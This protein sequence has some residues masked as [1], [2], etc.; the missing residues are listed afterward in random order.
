MP[1]SKNICLRFRVENPDPVITF[2]PIGNQVVIERQHIFLDGTFSGDNLT[3]YMQV[4]NLS[5][6]P[7]Q[8]IVINPRKFLKNIVEPHPAIFKKNRLHIL[9]MMTRNINIKI[10]FPI[11]THGYFMIIRRA[12]PAYS[13]SI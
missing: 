2:D 6:L 12:N 7:Y 8:V 11:E 4:I 10:A 3:I 9:A 13:R 1:D 5:G